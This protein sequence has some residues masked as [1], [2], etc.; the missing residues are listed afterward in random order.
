MGPH[1]FVILLTCLLGLG[2]SVIVVNQASID[3]ERSVAFQTAE[4]P[5][6]LPATPDPIRL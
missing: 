5:Q 2:L 3:A 6:A 4:A 1:Q